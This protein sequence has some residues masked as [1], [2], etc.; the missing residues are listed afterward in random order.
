MRSFVLSASALSLLLIITP[1][2]AVSAGS[3]EPATASGITAGAHHETFIVE[4]AVTLPQNCYAARIRSTPISLHTPRSFYV[5]QLAPSSPCASKTAYKCTVV[6]PDFPL[7]IP[8][9]I[10]VVS[11]GPQRSKVTVSTEEEPNPAPP[12]CRKG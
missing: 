10:E 2:S 8:H 7:P 3:W 9:Q 12:L 1:L 11:K 6:S 4:A 5:E